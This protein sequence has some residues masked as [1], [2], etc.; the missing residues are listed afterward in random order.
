MSKGKKRKQD[1]PK[2]TPEASPSPSPPAVAQ[3]WTRIEQAVLAIFVVC[4]VISVGAHCI[5]ITRGLAERQHGFRQTQ[6]AISAFWMLRGGPWLAYETPVLGPPWSIPFEFPLYQWLVALAAAPWPSALDTV[7]RAMSAIL[8]FVSFWPAFV[9]LRRFGAAR[10]TTFATLSLY[11]LSPLYVFWSATFMIESTAILLCLL[12]LAFLLDDRRAAPAIV[13]ITSALAALVKVTTYFGFAIAAAFM[14]VG[15]AVALRRGGASLAS[16]VRALWLRA[17][18]AGPLPLA[19]ALFWTRFSDAK[20]QEVPFARNFITSA[21]LDSWNFGTRDQKLS[22]PI[23]RQ[24][25]DRTDL[26]LIGGHWPILVAVVVG[27]VFGRARRVLLAAAF[28]Y[29]AVFATF[30]NLHMVHNYYPYANGVFILAAVGLGV[31]A[32]L[33]R[34]KPWAWAGVAALCAILVG[35]LITYRDG[36]LKEQTPSDVVRPLAAAIRE[37]TK[38]DDV[39]L[40]YGD[41]WSSQIPYYA[42]RRTIMDNKT[43]HLD[44]PDMRETLALLDRSGLQVGAAALCGGLK[45]FEPLVAMLEQRLQIARVPIY[46]DGYC[47]VRLR[48]RP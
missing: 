14:L 30:T 12:S 8:Y 41:D 23:W 42:E 15:R 13:A 43:R 21:A 3:R 17:V 27:L 39:L 40:V 19:C 10:S 16:V 35:Q 4:I 1:D 29:V 44:S 5:G 47:A 28:I 38:P 31:G 33:E 24:I 45:S 46:S 26:D 18:I 7:G 11:A 37:H 20:K 6:T 36:Y 22:W 9:I 25:L 34:E 2:L 48:V 32:L